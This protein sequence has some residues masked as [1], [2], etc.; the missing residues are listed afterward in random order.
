MNKM[1]TDSALT[2]VA[3]LA[4]GALLTKLYDVTNFHPPSPVF[5]FFIGFNAT[6]AVSLFKR[7][8]PDT[9]ATGLSGFGE[10]AA[11]IDWKI[12]VYE[13]NMAGLRRVIRAGSPKGRIK[14][15]QKLAMA[16]R[17]LAALRRRRR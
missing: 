9:K 12:R 17:N 7:Y 15:K 13:D 3:T 5:W 10:S 16:Q 14:A 2:G 1:L 4:S 6:L 11:S 8:S